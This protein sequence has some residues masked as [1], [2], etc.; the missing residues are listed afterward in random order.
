MPTLFQRMWS[1]CRRRSVVR[2][3]DEELQFHREQLEAEFQRKGLPKDEAALAAQRELGNLTQSRED[4]RDRAGLPWLEDGMRD[5]AS[6]ARSL[7]RRPF[8]AVS[9]ITILALGIAAAGVVHGLVSA[10]FLR[11]LEIPQPHQIFAV[12]S[13]GPDKVSRS[14]VA[15]TEALLGAEKVGGYSSTSHL[16]VS[17]EGENVA[18]VSARLV[19]GSFFPMLGVV[20]WQGRLLGTSDDKPGNP[21]RVAVASYG[22]AV[23]RFGAPEAAV[24]RRLLIGGEAVDIVGVLPADFRDL[25]PGQRTDLWLPTAVQKAVRFAGDAHV[26]SSDD[27]PN[28]TDWCTEERVAWLNVLLRLPSRDPK[29]ASAMFQQAYASQVEEWA[30][31]MTDPQEQDTLRRKRWQALP[32]PT[33]P[34][35]GREKYWPTLQL[36]GGIVGTLLILSCANVS[37]LLLVRTMSRHRELAVRLALGAG[38]WRA[39]RLLV[40]EALLLSVLAGIVGLLLI[41]WGLPVAA[42]LLATS[43]AVA[44]EL[45]IDS[46]IF[47]AGVVAFST[48]ASAV[49]PILFIRRLQPLSMLTGSAG[50]LPSPG[51]LGRGLVMA[52]LALTVVLVAVAYGLGDELERTLSANYGFESERVLTASVSPQ[53][54]GYSE[55]AQVELMQRLRTAAQT[56]AG[57]E[58][59]AFAANGV[60]SGSLSRSGIYP[61]GESAR[62]RQ[63]EYQADNVTPGYI[64]TIGLRLLRGR[65]IEPMDTSPS[66][67]VAIVTASFA[68]NVFGTLDVLGQRFGFDH[69]P[70]DQDWTVVGVVAD[71]RVNGLRSLPPAM[72]FVPLTPSEPNFRFIVVRVLSAVDSVRGP[73]SAAIA[74][75]EPRLKSLEWKT[76]RQRANESMHGDVKTIR[77]ATLIAG[78]AMLLAS[79]GIAASLSYLVLMRRKE[80]AVRI[81][82]GASPESL[83]RGVLREAARLALI[84]GA[85]GALGTWYF[86]RIPRIASLLHEPPGL[87]TLAISVTLVTS[88]SCLAA[89]LP[90][91][92]AARTDPLV[93]LKTE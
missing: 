65:D 75:A 63:G 8:F 62:I 72:F 27:R 55:E 47:A 1:W 64:K 70:S 42:N 58:E 51:R 10:I 22:W 59:V 57:V 56:V 24:G 60:M 88:L 49:A 82:I 23:K 67:R 37:G 50:A 20:A 26:F 40:V 54:A 61:R 43:G 90:A 18:F 79:T 92:R 45:R 33:G 41:V 28:N 16:S 69:L 36:L 73:L 84:G 74:L 9:V 5:L 68:E 44:P 3:F 93:S 19:S 52:Q 17:S 29:A 21:A 77:L 85:I 66:V 38:I 91:I 71:A 76:P 11:P 15:R 35:A 34:A 53:Q 78:L 25:S 30:R 86:P 81:A 89:L 31:A 7:R 13:Q 12:T 32:A 14:T 4:L 39:T 83:V 48:L 6:S 46:L 80:L 2:R 87:L